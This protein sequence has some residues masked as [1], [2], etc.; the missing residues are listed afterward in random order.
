MF[1]KIQVWGH[2]NDDKVRFQR[3]VA[4]LHSNNPAAMDAALDD[5]EVFFVFEKGEPVLGMHDDFT[6][7]EKE[8]C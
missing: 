5:D 8:V 1:S 4:V 7:T 3:T 2:W 6:I